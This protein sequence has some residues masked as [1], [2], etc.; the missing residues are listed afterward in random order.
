MWCLRCFRAFPVF[1][2]YYLSEND[3]PT[4]RGS[5]ARQDT[6]PSLFCWIEAKS[7]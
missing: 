3:G 6:R 7:L 2:F 1:F 4:L 5:K